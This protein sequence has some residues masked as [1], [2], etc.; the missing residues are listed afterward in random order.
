MNS[1]K[2]TLSENH[3]FFPRRPIVV[4]DPEHRRAVAHSVKDDVVTTTPPIALRII[5][6]NIEHELYAFL[7]TDLTY[8]LHSKNVTVE[9]EFEY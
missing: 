3:S 4:I 7:N 6:V 2:K 8:A 5:H 9:D 1:E